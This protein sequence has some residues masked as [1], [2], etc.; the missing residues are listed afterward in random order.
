MAGRCRQYGV[1]SAAKFSFISQQTTVL[2]TTYKILQQYN[3]NKLSLQFIADLT[4][5]TVELLR[6]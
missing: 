6:L 4:A 3:L 2:V 1:C 5:A